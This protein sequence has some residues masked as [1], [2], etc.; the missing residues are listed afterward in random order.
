[1]M[2]RSISAAGH[3]ARLPDPPSTCTGYRRSAQRTFLLLATVGY[4]RQRCHDIE[5]RVTIDLAAGFGSP[6]E[7][8][9]NGI[10][11]NISSPDDRRSMTYKLELD[12]DLPSSRSWQMLFTAY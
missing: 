3:A 8:I 12:L 2:T 1:M 4:M 7:I 5:A 11:L 6:I 10:I 9:R